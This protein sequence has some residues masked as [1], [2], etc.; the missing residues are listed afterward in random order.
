MNEQIAITL[1]NQIKHL[2]EASITNKGYAGINDNTL[3][4]VQHKIQVAR[5]N[6]LI[7][8]GTV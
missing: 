1:Y 4:A 2:I 6:Y 5:L 7:N 8:L 3:T